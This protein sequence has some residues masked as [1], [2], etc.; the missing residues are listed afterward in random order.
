MS[1]GKVPTRS[2]LYLFSY[3][4]HAPVIQVLV[5]A[6]FQLVKRVVKF[7]VYVVLIIIGLIGLID[8]YRIGKQL[9]KLSF[10]DQS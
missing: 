10:T 6:T 1:R 3:I 9:G 7:R 5:N 2:S 8:I 4:A